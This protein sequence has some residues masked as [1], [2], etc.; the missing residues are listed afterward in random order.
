MAAIGSMIQAVDYSTPLVL[1][2]NEIT[3]LMALNAV[4]IITVMALS[5]Y[6]AIS[7]IFSKGSQALSESHFARK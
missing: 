3:V 1:E 6:V 2:F 5:I 7:G 4:G